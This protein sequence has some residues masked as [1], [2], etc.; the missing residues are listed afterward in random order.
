[1]SDTYYN[2]A[3]TGEEIDA[4]VA[5]AM[6]AAP[7]STTYKKN[8]VD[9][10][11]AAKQNTLTTAQLAAANS[12]IT[13][14]KVTQYDKDSAAVAWGVDNGAKNIANIGAEKT[15]YHATYAVSGQEITVTSSGNYARVSIPVHAKAGSYKFSC[16]VTY[17][18]GAVE[19]RFAQNADSTGTIAD[20]IT[21]SASGNVSGDITLETDMDFYIVLYTNVTS[22]SA[23][24]VVGFSN[25][26]ICS[27]ADYAVST[28]FAPYAPT[29]REL[30]EMILAMQA[31]M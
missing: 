30:Y 17:S 7:Q 25:I 5:A 24:N 3:Y 26:M 6:A 28:A 9:A 31:G 14:A 13:S 22:S 15:A 20:K 4:A 11:L 23:S 18:S 1:M 10:A 8:E 21:V 29:N 2:G 12:G 19:I 27:A 16:G